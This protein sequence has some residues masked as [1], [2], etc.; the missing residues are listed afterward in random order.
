METKE[1]SEK[2]DGLLSKFF[3]ATIPA[4]VIA[5]ATNMMNKKQASEENLETRSTLAK[6][7]EKSRDNTERQLNQWIEKYDELS[8]KYNDLLQSGYSRRNAAS[9][10]PVVSSRTRAEKPTKVTEA[11]PSPTLTADISGA[12]KTSDGT[13]AWT[14]TNGRVQ[15]KSTDLLP[16]MVSGAGT[17][18]Q[19]NEVIQGT[20]DTDVLFYLPINVSMKFN[21][22]LL[23]HGRVIAG[24]LTDPQGEVTAVSLSR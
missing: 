2:K 4:I 15:V 12:W 9:H 20:V 3:L 13:V 23:D 22:Q 8:N 17:Y 10:E 11:E 19:N 18:R 21:G 1:K 16:G 7:L 6:Q 5:Y 24:T 14:F